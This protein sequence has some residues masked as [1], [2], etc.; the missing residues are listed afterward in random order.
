[1]HLMVWALMAITAYGQCECCKER[2]V[3]LPIG[4][5][6]VVASQAPTVWG[7]AGMPMI[8]VNATVGGMSPVSRSLAWDA[9]TV[10]ILSRIG[11]PGLKADYIQVAQQD[12]RTYIRVACFMLLEVTPGDA[13]AAATTV[14]ELAQRWVEQV[15]RVLPEIAPAR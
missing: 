13:R 15:R 11:A 14:P 3:V 12:G 2:L 10:E 7:I 1:M 4:R 6:P 8:Q 9:R 5:T